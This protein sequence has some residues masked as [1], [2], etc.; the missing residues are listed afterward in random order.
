MC[1]TI[2]SVR[3]SDVAFSILE[4]PGPVRLVAVD[5]PG[6]AGK[7]TFAAMLAAVLGG[8]PVVHTDDFASWDDPT[9]WWP[10]CFDQVVEPL[11]RG[12]SARYQ[13]YDWQT[14]SLA[15]WI[16]VDPEP[17][18]IIEGVSAGRVEWRR[19]LAFVI[20]IETPPA[21]RLRRGLERDGVEA[22]D[23]WVSWGA[24]EDEHYDSDPTRRHAD[25]VVDGTVPSEGDEFV[26]IAPEASS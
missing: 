9:G 21:E 2:R 14:R 13:R 15:D 25:L 24:A 5:G 23:D 22:L 6:G 16:D 20:W 1:A 12:R 8:A 10:R 7:T 26:A 4:R 11:S 17:V 3:F 19:Y 18:V